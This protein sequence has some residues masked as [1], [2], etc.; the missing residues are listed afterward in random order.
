MRTLVLNTPELRT[1]LLKAYRSLGIGLSEG[2]WRSLQ[3]ASRQL[4]AAARRQR[5]EWL[6]E[7]LAESGLPKPLAWVVEKRLKSREFTPEELA[8][9]IESARQSCAESGIAEVKRVS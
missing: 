1:G 8:T 4:E 2:E 6:R 9:E 5:L 3:G 7:A